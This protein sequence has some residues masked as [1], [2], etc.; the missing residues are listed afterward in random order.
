[1]KFSLIKILTVYF[2]A[3]Q[4]FSQTSISLDTV[5][6]GNNGNKADATGYGAVSYDYY[7]G[8]HEVTNSEYSSVLNAIAAT[9]TY[10]LWHKSMSIDRTGSSGD[11]TYSVLDGKGEHPVVRVNFYDAARFANWLMNGQPTG[12]QDANT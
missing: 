7:I 6:V 4:A 1:M 9:D 8:K 3:S 11:Y 2:F 5:F 12:A 10:G